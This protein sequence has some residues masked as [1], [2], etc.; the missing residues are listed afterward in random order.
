MGF[1]AAANAWVVVCGG[2]RGGEGMR[3]TLGPPMGVRIYEI[4]LVRLGLLVFKIQQVPPEIPRE[5]TR[6]WK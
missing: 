2:I 4:D 1:R 3:K 6:G 5:K